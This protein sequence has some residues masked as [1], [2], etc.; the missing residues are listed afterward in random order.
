MLNTKKLSLIVLLTLFIF[1]LFAENYNII[2][3]PT[4]ITKVGGFTEACVI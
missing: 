4:K 2:P 1:P 3:E